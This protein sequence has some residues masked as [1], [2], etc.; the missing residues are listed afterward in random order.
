MKDLESG[1]ASL[2]G[3]DCLESVSVESYSA[4]NNGHQLQLEIS[5]ANT[6]NGSASGANGL[7]TSGDVCLVIEQDPSATK[8]KGKLAN[9]CAC[10]TRRLRLATLLTSTSLN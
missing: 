3:V 5:G 9:M 1:A 10:A 7:A 8:V 6:D 4:A 2:E